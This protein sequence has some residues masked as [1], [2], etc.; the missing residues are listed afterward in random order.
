[1][2]SHDQDP[3]YLAHA[4]SE[5]VPEGRLATDWAPR[6]LL[7]AMQTMF[8]KHTLRRKKLPVQLDLA[9][10]RDE[11]FRYDTSSAPQILDRVKHVRMNNEGMRWVYKDDGAYFHA[12]HDLDVPYDEFVRHVDIARVGDCFRDVLGIH[13]H[14]LRRDEQGRSLL[15]V[16]RIAA[17][18]QPNY[19]AFLGKDELDV[20]KLE[21][22]TYGPDEVRNWMR[23]VCSPNAST[24]ADDGYMAFRRRADGGGTH[25]EFVA[26]QSFPLPRVM[27][28]LRLDRWVWYRNFL[29]RH[30]Y[31]RFWHETLANMLARY[32]GRTFAVGRVTA[33]QPADGGGVAAEVTARGE[34]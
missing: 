22:M 10:Y 30:A 23:T 19:A 17:L 15:Q 32:E 7:R 33:A 29:T 24:R 4:S 5:T 31:R 9:P 34:G 21:A 6:T 27:V 13:T 8:L 18:P 20:Y 26:N 28:L 25:I 12:V 14:V 2:P 1:M 3:L 16:E 11:T